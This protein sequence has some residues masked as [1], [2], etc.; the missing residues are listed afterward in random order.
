MVNS[1]VETL[2]G[3]NTL[4]RR[5]Q[6]AVVTESILKLIHHLLNH[7]YR[8]ISKQA[9]YDKIVSDLLDIS[10]KIIDNYFVG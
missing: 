6:S 8:Y 10:N 1:I 3:L 9:K 7:F 4:V 2:L 5:K